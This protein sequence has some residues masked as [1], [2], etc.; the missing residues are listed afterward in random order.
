MVALTTAEQVQQVLHSPSMKHQV[1]QDD[2]EG[3]DKEEVT[4]QGHHHHTTAVI[5]VTCSIDLAAH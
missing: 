4:L 5:K 1:C 2:L 3:N